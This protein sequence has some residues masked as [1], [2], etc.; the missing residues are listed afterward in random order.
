MKEICNPLGIDKDR[1][2]AYHGQGNSFA[3]QNIRTLKDVMRSILLHCRLSRLKWRSILPEIMFA[4][5]T[6]QS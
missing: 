1:S 4:L 6:S 2:S 3:E 5:N